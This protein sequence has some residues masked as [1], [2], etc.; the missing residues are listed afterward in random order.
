MTTTNKQQG[1]ELPQD[2]RAALV[3]QLREYA[4][5]SG[6]SHNDY[7]DT[8]RQAAE[9]LDQCAA[10]VPAQAAAY[11]RDN[12]EMIYNNGKELSLFKPSEQEGWKPLYFAVPAAAPVQGDRHYPHIVTAEALDAFAQKRGF[13]TAAQ[14]IAAAS[15]Q[16]NSGR[17]AALVEPWHTGL[18]KDRA[19][20]DGRTSR[21]EAMLREIAAHRLAAH[22]A[23][24]SDVALVFAA[25]VAATHMEHAKKLLKAAGFIMEGGTVSGPYCAALESLQA[26]LAAHPANGAQAG[27]APQKKEG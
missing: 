13:K 10:S 11:I 23:P 9:E 21:E 18:S 4:D 24:S 6:Y 15:V 2:E 3:V 7:A 27:A 5:N 26:A 1:G 8:M 16:P 14:A 22:P 17:D 20:L 19:Y 12:P 25:K